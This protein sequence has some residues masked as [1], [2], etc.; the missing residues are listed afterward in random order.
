MSKSS[1]VSLARKLDLVSVEDFLAGEL[2]SSLKHEY[3][4]GV[5]YA[6]AGARNIRFSP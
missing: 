3:L 6:L 2:V 4:G 1:W 5:V